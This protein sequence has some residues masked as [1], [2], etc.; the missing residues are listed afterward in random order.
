MANRFAAKFNL[1]PALCVVAIFSAHANQLDSDWITVSNLISG[2]S[3]QITSPPSSVVTTKYTGG[4]LLGNGDIGVAIGDT[5]GRQ[6]FRFGKLDFWGSVA[7]APGDNSTSHQYVWQQGAMTVGG[8]TLS[9]PNAGTSQSSVYTMTQDILNAEDRTMM[10]FANQVGTKNV[11]VSMTAWTAD[12]D[13]VF[14]VELSSPFGSDPV[15]L[16]LTNFVPCQYEYQN[17][18]QDSSNVYPYAAG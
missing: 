8:L 9:S 2:Y 3:A 6:T 10:Q 17:V 7:K 5:T 1:M 14:V 12:T 16:N 15:T 4:Q 13:N 11:N 18:W